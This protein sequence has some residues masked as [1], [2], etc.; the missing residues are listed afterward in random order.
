MSRLADPNTDAD[1]IYPQRS[2]PSCLAALF[3]LKQY[4]GRRAYLP[5]ASGLLVSGAA[6]LVPP[7]VLAVAVFAVEGKL[8]TYALGL[9]SLATGGLPAWAVKSRLWARRTMRRWQLRTEYDA[10]VARVT[11]NIVERDAAR[12]GE[13]VRGAGLVIEYARSS[14]GGDD[15]RNFHL[16]IAQWARSPQLDDVAFRDRLV[17]LFSQA[18][19][20]ANV[21]G[22]DVNQPTA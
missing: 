13:I 14:Y 6:F 4:E 8:A 9:A 3:E 10:S 12:T 7:A 22:I 2:V 17:G 1:T 21:A 5:Y 19:I 20:W 18:E 16:A 15:P 11:V